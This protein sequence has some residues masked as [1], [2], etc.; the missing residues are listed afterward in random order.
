[1]DFIDVPFHLTDIGSKIDGNSHRPYG[2]SD[3]IWVNIM[4]AA[5]KCG[6]HDAIR[7]C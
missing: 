6:A 7:I 3:K 1:M 5:N 2:P 4:G